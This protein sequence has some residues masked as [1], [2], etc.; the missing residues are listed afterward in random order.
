MGRVVAAIPCIKSPPCPKSML[1]STSVA[2]PRQSEYAE[3]PLQVASTP[4]VP[5]PI[6]VT[7]QPRYVP[8]AGLGTNAQRS[9]LNFTVHPPRPPVQAPSW[10]QRTMSPQTIDVQHLGLTPLGLL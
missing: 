7:I 3:V 1:R 4:S 6:G 5:V 8:D 9:K 10:I 2:K